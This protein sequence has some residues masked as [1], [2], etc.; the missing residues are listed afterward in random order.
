MSDKLHPLGF[1][2]QHE[3]KIIRLVRGTDG[4]EGCIAQTQSEC[5]ALPTCASVDDTPQVW[6]EATD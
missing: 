4:C 1:V 2:T 5:H 3:G 6:Q